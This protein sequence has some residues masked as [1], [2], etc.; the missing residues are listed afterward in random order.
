[1]T[2]HEQ[3]EAFLKSGWRS[4]YEM[5]LWVKS[6]CADSIARKIR[7]NPPSGY[8]Y[9]QRRRNIEGYRPCLEFHLA[10]S[11]QMTLF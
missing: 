8:V 11:G 9:L 6:S 3:I 2:L 7:Q 1:M 5:Q 10:P 4:N